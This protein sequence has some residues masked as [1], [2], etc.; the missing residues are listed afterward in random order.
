MGMRRITRIQPQ[1]Y[2]PSRVSVDIDGEFAF[3]LSMRAAAELSVGQELSEAELERIRDGAQDESALKKAFEYLARR[4]YSEA[5]LRG[6]LALKGYSEER[7][8][9]AIDRVR[10]LGYLNDRAFAENWIR[11]RNEFRPRG[12]RMLRYELKRKGVDETVIRE[13][14]ADVDDR[15]AAFACAERYSRRLRGLD[16]ETF[17]N[18][19]SGYLARRSF[20]YDVIRSAVRAAWNG[21]NA[22]GETGI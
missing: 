12:V 17:R 7:I 13:S 18:R 14:L 1:K 11:D 21:I 19:L 3:G 10:E 2:D 15:E 20:T 22:D 16:R 4:D 6:K 9:R 8:T 5:E